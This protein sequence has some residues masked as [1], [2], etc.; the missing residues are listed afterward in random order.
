MLLY[1]SVSSSFVRELRIVLEEKAIACDFVRE[2]P[3]EL[4]RNAQRLN[5]LGK[6]PVLA[7]DCGRCSTLR[8]SS[9]SISTGPTAWGATSTRS[10]ECPS[11]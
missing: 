5:P 6:V 1:G 7:L 3:R 4:G 11:L 8:P 2:N 10:S 9:S